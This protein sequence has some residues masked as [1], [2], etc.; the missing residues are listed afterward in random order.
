MYERRPSRHSELNPQH[1]HEEVRVDRPEQDEVVRPEAD[2]IDEL[3]RVGH[4]T[5][6]DSRWDETPPWLVGPGRRWADVSRY[7]ATT[8]T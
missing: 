1:A 6:G 7:A 3:L 5:V 2:M 8:V 4:G